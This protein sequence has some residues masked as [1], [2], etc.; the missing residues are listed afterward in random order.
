MTAGV[1]PSPPRHCRAAV[2]AGVSVGG[3]T[4]SPIH[5]RCGAARLRFPSALPI[6]RRCASPTA[7]LIAMKCS[8]FLALVVSA[9]VLAGSAGA[10]VNVWFVADGKPVSVPRNGST[11][12]E[13][14]R[15]AARRADGGRAQPWHP[16][17]RSAR[18]PAAL[19]H[20]RRSASSPSTSARASRPAATAR[21]LQDRVGQ[22]VRTPARHPRR[23]RRAGADRRRRAGRA[24][25]RLRPP[26]A[27]RGAGRAGRAARADDA[28]HPAAARRSRLHGALGPDRDGRHADVDRRAR[29]P[30]VGEPA[31]RRRRSAPRHDR[32]A[33]A[34]NAARARG[35][36]CPAAGSRCSFAASSRC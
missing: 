14:V 27:G 4:S 23:P 32:G 5:R 36:G 34:G 13:A 12:E 7:N 29:I 28:R 31:A 17:G 35:C 18:D 1:S 20:G 22:L 33:R 24:L 9:L 21:L 15:A 19:G 10:G 26:Q 3:V 30:E 2:A 11:L 25:P 16:L 8:A 6:G